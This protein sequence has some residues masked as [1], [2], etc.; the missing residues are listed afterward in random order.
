MAAFTADYTV[1]ARRKAR[2]RRDAEQRLAAAAAGAEDRERDR[3][4]RMRASAALTSVMPTIHD[5]GPRR[6]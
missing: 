1:K 6:V 5:R 3:R 4:A 2:L